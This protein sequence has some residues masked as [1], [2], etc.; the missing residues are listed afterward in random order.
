MDFE[1][2]VSEIEE[3]GWDVHGIEV[4]ERGKLTRRW[5]DTDGAVYDVFSVT[6]TV[7]SIAFGMACDRGK[8]S[9]DDLLMKY[10]PREKKEKMSPAQREAF[11]KITLR[12]L[13]TMSVGELPFQAAGESY[14]DFALGCAL[15]RPEEKTFNYSN[16]SAYLVGVALTEALGEDVGTFIERNL[17]APLGITKFSYERCPEGYF[18]GASRMKLTVNE[19]S[20]IGMLLCNGGVY[21]GRLLLSEQYVRTATSVQQMNR[22]GGYGYFIWKYRDG[23]SIT[24]K[25]GQRCCCLP[26][27]GLMITYLS[28]MGENARAL[29]ECMERTLLEG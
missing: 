4:Y 7:L 28:D 5:G 27:A 6:K 21:D 26:E 1:A 22:E 11:G 16:V 13:L 3:N 8:I 17:F 25:G 24:G 12:R 18:Y 23:F 15:Q 2:F 9:P 14:L 20:R 10:L 19:L 29:R